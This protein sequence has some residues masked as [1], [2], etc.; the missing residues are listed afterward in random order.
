M[1]T[2]WTIRA[3]VAMSNKSIAVKFLKVLRTATV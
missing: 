2:V 3:R 1:L